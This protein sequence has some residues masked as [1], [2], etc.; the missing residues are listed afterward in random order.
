M[1]CH[2]ELKHLSLLSP[3]CPIS[4]NMIAHI[5][6]RGFGGV[7]ADFIAVFTSSAQ[8]RSNLEWFNYTNQIG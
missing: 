3:E 5:I 4:A 6:M 2:S 8:W 7:R 1:R